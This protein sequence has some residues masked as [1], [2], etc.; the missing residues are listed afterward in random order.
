VPGGKSMKNPF[1]PQY[2]VF[3]V[4]LS[5]KMK[6]RKMIFV[7]QKISSLWLLR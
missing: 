3:S 5:E 2:S 7:Q 1:N 4:L 6:M